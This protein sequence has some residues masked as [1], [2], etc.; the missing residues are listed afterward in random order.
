[1]PEV[2]DA[3]PSRHV[4]A[5]GNGARPVRDVHT[6][7]VKGLAVVGFEATVTA[8]LVERLDVSVDHG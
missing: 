5:R 3:T 4:L 1:V 2:S 7:K 8:P 6:V